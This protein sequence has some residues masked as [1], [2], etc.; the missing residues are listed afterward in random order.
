M[1]QYTICFCSFSVAWLSEDNDVII[2]RTLSYQ[3]RALYSK[4]RAR[5]FLLQL[6]AYGLF[7]RIFLLSPCAKMIFYEDLLLSFNEGRK[8]N[9]KS[10]FNQQVT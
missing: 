6:K 3:I 9:H 5:F 1:N 4:V 2:N 10:F 8:I 7:P